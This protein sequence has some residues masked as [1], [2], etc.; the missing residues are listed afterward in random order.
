MTTYNL[1]MNSTLSAAEIAEVEA[2]PKGSL[3]DEDCPAC[4]YEELARMLAAKRDSEKTRIVSIR[5]NEETLAKM[6]S[7]GKGYTGVMS[8]VIEYAANN[9]EILKKCL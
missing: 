2:A 8:R 3:Q 1:D 5:L 9:P 4:S 6:K 7:L